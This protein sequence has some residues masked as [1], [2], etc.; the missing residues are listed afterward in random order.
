MMAGTFYDV[1]ASHQRS[2]A[3][4]EKLG[5]LKLTSNDTPIIDTNNENQIIGVKNSSDDNPI[6]DT[7]NE[8]LSVGHLSVRRRLDPLAEIDLDYA[9]TRNTTGTLY[10]TTGTLYDATGTFYN[11]T[12]TLCYTTGTLYNTISEVYDTTWIGYVFG[13]SIRELGLNVS[14]C[15]S[16]SSGER[17]IGQ[18]VNG[19]VASD[20]AS[21]VTGD[22]GDVTRG[23][24]G[25]WPK[26]RRR[27]LVEENNTLT[28]SVFVDRRVTGVF[29]AGGIVG[30]QTEPFV[31]NVVAGIDDAHL[32][33]G[34][35]CYLPTTIVG[36]IVSVFAFGLAYSLMA[37]E[38]K[39]QHRRWKTTKFEA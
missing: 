12:G 7:K 16:V 37:N 20:V 1:E 23:C 3:A 32:C 11:T 34:S 35:K 25:V 14:D 22:T 5:H 33:R 15:G 17:K 39:R 6:I 29:D 2:A 8:N 28:E 27:R 19:D 21:D 9:A 31:A 30:I 13:E 38:Q 24:L 26:W 36:V 4:A 10:N 18:R